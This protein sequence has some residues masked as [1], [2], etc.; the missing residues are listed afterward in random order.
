M[1]KITETTIDMWAYTWVGS[2]PCEDCD[3]Y[4]NCKYLKNEERCEDSQA[5]YND[6]LKEYN[7]LKAK[8]L[9]S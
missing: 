8:Y 6:Y 1:S 7:R 5:W 2:S 9:N 3:N 4:R